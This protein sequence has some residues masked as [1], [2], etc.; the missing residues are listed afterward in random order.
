[1]YL[2]FLVTY[3]PSMLIWKQHLQILLPILNSACPLQS[4]HASKSHQVV[5]RV[6]GNQRTIIDKSDY[7]YNAQLHRLGELSS[8]QQVYFSCKNSLVAV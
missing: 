8:K 2:L 1:M 3:L 6:S 7:I 4:L 5:F